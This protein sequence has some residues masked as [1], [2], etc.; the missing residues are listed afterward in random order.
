MNV[1]LRGFRR[2][3]APLLV[4]SLASA[5]ACD[6][7]P[8]LVPVRLPPP[9]EPLPEHTP[10]GPYPLVSQCEDSEIRVSAPRRVEMGNVPSLRC[11]EAYQ[12]D[13]VVEGSPGDAM[14]LDMFQVHPPRNWR[15]DARGEWVRHEFT[16]QMDPFWLAS[17]RNLHTSRM[18]SGHEPMVVQLC[19]E[20]EGAGEVLA[21]TTIA[22]GIYNDVSEVPALMPSKLEMAMTLPLEHQRTI[23]F[24][25]GGTVDIPVTFWIFRPLLEDT[26]VVLELALFEDR[27][28]EEADF[29]ISPEELVIPAGS[30][31]TETR[32]ARV[33]VTARKASGFLTG[34]YLFDVYLTP[35]GVGRRCVNPPPRVLSFNAV[36]E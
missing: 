4:A 27:Y 2:L 17:G 22:C 28:L 20:G 9:P 31:R 15:V 10:R 33:T 34:N 7:P 13:F 35:W 18:F 32:V 11:S 1:V 8:P 26:G 25:V 21:C 36:H 23:K 30:Q 14:L 5:S 29:R 12:V 6:E 3:A 24:P 19:P 16:L